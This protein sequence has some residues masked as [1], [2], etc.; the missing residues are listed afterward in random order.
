M[1]IL[2]Q[3][4]TEEQTRARLNSAAEYIQNQRQQETEEQRRARQ[5]ADAQAHR[6]RYS[7]QTPE[8]HSQRL[9]QAQITRQE[10]EIVPSQAL[11]IY[12][13][14]IESGINAEPF[15]CG[16][17]NVICSFCRS[18]N[19]LG[20]RPSDG[21]FSYCCQKGKVKLPKPRD[22]N[23]CE[24]EYPDFLRDLMTNKNNPLHSVFK[25]QIRS[26]NNAVSFASMGAKIVDVPGRG[27]Y[28][29]KIHGQTCHKTSHLQPI[30]NQQPQYAQLYIINSTQATGIRQQ[31]QANANIPAIILDQIDRFFRQHNRIAHSYQMMREI[32]ERHAAQAILTGEAP[33]LISL[34]F[35]RDRQSDPRRFNDP[36]GN[37]IAIVFQSEDGEPPFERDIRIYPRNPQNSQQPFVNINILSPNLPMT[38]ALLNPYGTAGWQPKWQCESYP[39]AK[40][41]RV[42]KNVSMMQYIVAKTAIRDSF[43]P[44]LH[45]GKLTQQYFVDAYSR[46]AANNLNYIRQN[47]KK[48]R[49][50]LYQGL[51]DHIDNMAADH[52]ARPGVPVI[53]PS[54]FSGSPRNMREMCCDAMATFASLLIAQKRSCYNVAAKS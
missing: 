35:R 1:Q 23:G 26:I 11:L 51:V 21:F 9:S 54:T 39:N 5:I 40:A 41:N 38:Y 6:L 15:Y 12:A 4:E 29:F 25:E 22:E 28:V 20:E 32:E 18:K 52:N 30:N 3:Q 36:V 2:R 14:C 49:A 34:I 31:H 53:L 33:P 46:V 48:L 37:E 24:L 7:N 17:M 45:A 8:E 50:E 27:P 10:T 16:E 42:R 43:N 13:G 44:I 47:Q 19:F